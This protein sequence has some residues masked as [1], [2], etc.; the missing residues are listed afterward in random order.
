VSL[1]AVS[2]SFVMSALMH[3]RLPCDEYCW[4]GRFFNSSFVLDERDQLAEVAR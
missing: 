4:N 3:R 2:S 1:W